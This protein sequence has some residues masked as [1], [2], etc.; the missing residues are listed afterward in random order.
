MCRINPKNAGGGSYQP[1]RHWSI[2]IFENVV[3]APS[4]VSDLSHPSNGRDGHPFQNE[5]R[6]AD[7]SAEDRTFVLW[8]RRRENKM[9]PRILL[10]SEARRVSGSGKVGGV[11]PRWKQTKPSDQCQSA[12]Q[13]HPLDIIHGAA[14]C[15]SVLQKIQQWIAAPQRDKVN[16]ARLRP[17]YG[18]VRLHFNPRLSTFVRVFQSEF[19]AANLSDVSNDG[20]A[21]QKKESPLS[22][23][24][25]APCSAVQDKSRT[26][27]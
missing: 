21:E 9:M 2:C 10:R 22:P 16:T 1:L 17:E 23:I 14:G 5:T 25:L 8:W 12:N 18:V 3:S 4:E 24:S 6:N 19:R 15:F 11:K 13:D 7:F 27:E 26:R 20:V